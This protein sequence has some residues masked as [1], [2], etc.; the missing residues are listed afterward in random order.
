[1]IDRKLEEEDVA[2][3]VE[4]SDMKTVKIFTPFQ[5]DWTDG[6]GNTVRDWEGPRCRRRRGGRAM[7]TPTRQ[8]TTTQVTWHVGYGMIGLRFSAK[9]QPQFIL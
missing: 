7:G 4:E 1:M 3:L 6:K 9:N 8:R 2:C 5:R